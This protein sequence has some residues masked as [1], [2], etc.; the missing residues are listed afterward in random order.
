MR[1]FV[2]VQQE[3]ESVSH[4]GAYLRQRVE[5]WAEIDEV[6]LDCWE[7]CLKFMY[8]TEKDLRKAYLVE[9]ETIIQF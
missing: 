5:E 7:D 4:K 3:F 2:D 9:L 6:N 8:E 1:E